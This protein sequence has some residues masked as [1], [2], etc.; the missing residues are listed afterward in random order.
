MD[1]KVRTQSLVFFRY[2]KDLSTDINEKHPIRI[3]NQL[4]GWIYKVFL[5]SSPRP[6][7]ADGRTDDLTAILSVI[8]NAEKYIYI[9][10]NEYI[11]MDLWKKRQPWPVIDDQ[12]R[13]G[14]SLFIWFDD[15]SWK[16]LKVT[17]VIKR[18]VHLKI[19]VNSKAS[20]KSLMLKHLQKLKQVNP[21]LI[22]MKIYDVSNYIITIKDGKRS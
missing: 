8:K 14:T 18:Q 12:L 20:H 6:L 4:D 22:E 11:P 9:A 3:F 7:C 2:P 16:G 1:V 21:Q 5:G 15:I 10:V 13:E 17:A 19:L